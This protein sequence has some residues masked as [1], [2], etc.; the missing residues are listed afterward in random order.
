MD[1]SGYADL[2][3]ESLLTGDFVITNL[4][5]PNLDPNSVPYIDSTNTVQDLILSDGQLVIGTTGGPPVNAAITGTANQVIV[6]DG[7]GSIGL[8]LPQ[9]IATFSDPTFH[10]LTVTDINGKIGNDL[11]TGP[12]SAVNNNL[13]SFNGTS[14]KVISDSGVLGTNIFLRDGSRTATGDFDMNNHELKNVKAIRPFTPNV[15]IGN[16]TSL[17]GVSNGQ[18]VIGDFT[19]TTSDNAICIGLQNTAKGNSVAIGKETISGTLATVVGYKSSMGFHTDT[20]IYGHD[21]FSSADS[22]DIFGVNQTNNQINSLLLGNGSYQNI[23]ATGGVCDLGTSSVPFQSLYSNA[24]VIGTVNSRLTNDIVSNTST[25]ASGNLPKFVSD[26]VIQ[27]SGIAASTITGGPFLKLD[28]TSSMTGDID[29]NSHKL[30]NVS[31]ITVSSGSGDILIG[32]ST[33]TSGSAGSISIGQGSTA[34][35]DGVALGQSCVSTFA[36]VCIGQSCTSANAA[37]VCIGYHA[38]STFS[39]GNSVCVGNSTT[40][41]AGRGVAV[42][43]HA[44]AAG[45]AVSIGY[46]SSANNSFGIALGNSATAGA[47]S[48]IAIGSSTSNSVTN[49]CLIGN[50]SIANIRPNNNNVCDLGVVTTNAFKDVYANGSLIGAVKTSAIDSIVTGPGSATGDNICTFNST[51]GKI[52]KDS[53]L[54]VFNVVAD[55]G[56]ATIGNLASY[57]ASKTI[58]DSGIVA[59]N[60]FFADGTRSMSGVL[61]QSNTTDSTLVSNGSIVTLGGIGIAKE[62]TVGGIIKGT[63]TTD[64]TT[65]TTG[66]ILSAGGAG[67]A[68]QITAGGKIITADT[69][70]ATTTTTGSIQGAGLGLSK[71][72]FAGGKI[73][74]SDTTDA[75]SSTVGG[76]VTAGG[77]ACAKQIRGGST[78]NITTNAAIGK[79]TTPTGTLEVVGPMYCT[80]NGGLADVELG[81]DPSAGNTYSIVTCYKQSVG[82]RDLQLGLKNLAVGANGGTPSFGGAYG[83]I[84]IANAT[85]TPGSTPSGGGVLYVTGGALTYKG[86]SGHIT[87]IA[88]A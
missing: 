20:N 35:D 73:T 52:I 88:I 69:T 21:N 23:R 45:N 41:N 49:S 6:T 76:L 27:D 39:V 5:L 61:N 58:H 62:I 3:N 56:T 16:S 19:T 4:I 50:S 65:S 8:S 59:T 33:V 42:G 24:S 29:A 77:L 75:T 15:N 2:L 12:A 36:S 14:G 64:S 31:Q 70:D 81:L 82:D 34:A 32:N 11:V 67:I 63:L 54:S 10:D 71:A 17:S 1:N 38:A 46:A 80:N 74:T 78:M 44:I 7:P 28:G 66:A 86:S 26:K 79:T 30:N 53:L 37:D 18:I 40:C 55:T 9:D 57:T 87:T 68:K 51:T 47:A 22:A 83:G 43:D 13:A 48:A 25:G 84:F 60:V 72:L 85:T